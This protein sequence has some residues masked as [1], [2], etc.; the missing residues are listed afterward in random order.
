MMAEKNDN[1]R[2]QMYPLLASRGVVVFP[3][4]VVPLLVGRDKSVEALEEAMLADKKIVVAAQ[5]DETVEEPVK[6]DLYRVGTITEVKQLVK[7]PNGMIKVIVEG[8]ERA[9]IL[10]FTKIDQYFAV[11]IETFKNEEME[12]L[13][14]IEADNEVQALLRSVINEFQKYVKFNP[15]LPAETVV[16]V[17]NIEEP[18]R[19]ADVIASHLELKYKK[20]QKLLEAISWKERLYTLLEILNKEIEILKIEQDI[21]KK[22]RKQVEKTQKEYYLKEKIKA[23]REELEEDGEDD[24]IKYYRNKLN[25]FQLPEKATEKVEQEIDKLKKTPGISPEATVIR[26][27]LDCVLDLPWNKE[28]EEKIDINRAEKILNEDHYDLEDVKRE[29][30]NLLLSG[31]WLHPRKVPFYA[32]WVHRVLVKHHWGVLLPEP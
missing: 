23:I 29:F 6:D 19:L 4:M 2:E 27:Y 30:W 16:S 9:R 7:L 31:N 10:E 22:V 12:E 20:E 5:K 26:N 32:W 17:V 28:K 14:R 3:Y 21:N 13:T 24:E 8:I 25:Q 11:S 15:N 18:G 1:N